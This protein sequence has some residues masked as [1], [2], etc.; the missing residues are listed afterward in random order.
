MFS[1]IALRNSLFILF[2]VLAHAGITYGQTTSFTYQGRLTD[3]GSAATATFDMQFKLFDGGGNQVGSTITNS[4]VTVTDGVFTVLLNFGATAFSGA[5][6]FLEIGIRPGGSPDAYTI[7]NPRQPVTSTPYAIRAANTSTADTATNATQL[8]GVNADQY[9]LTTDPRLAG[10]NNFIQNGNTQQAA[11]FN[12]SGNGNAAGILS[13]NVVNAATQY[14]LGATRFIS[15]PVFNTVVVGYSAGHSA[16]ASQDSTFVGYFAGS[17]STGQYNTFVGASTGRLNTTGE[18]NTFIGTYAGGSTKTGSYNSFVGY[19]TG[20]LNLS[21]SSNTFVGNGAGA[22]ANADGNS[23]FGKLAGHDTTTGFGNSFFGTQ[24][25]HDNKTASVNSFFGYL[26]GTNNTAIGNSFFGAYAGERN[27]TGQENSFF[28]TSAGRANLTA[29]GNAYFGDQSGLQST[30]ANNSFFGSG[31]GV[32][33]VAGFNNVFLGR[34]AGSINST[35]FNNTIIGTSA[36]VSAGGL[37][38]ATAIGS[39]ATVGTSNTI[40][41]GRDSGTD[42]VQI[43]G[44]LSVPK[45]G[46]IGVTS[47]CRNALNQLSTCS[48][49]LRYKKDI[50]PFTGGLALLNK[51]NPITFNWRTDNSPDLGFGAEEIAAIEPLLVVRDEKG[52]VEGV[53]YDRIT[54]VLVNAIK[55]QQQQINLQQ[56]QIEGLKKFICKR[57]RRARPCLSGSTQ[58]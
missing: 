27:T 11:N 9:V 29:T 55:E 16:S 5:D 35:G 45:L 15:T 56:Q 10:G 43:P 6:R 41:L 34:F 7:L 4:S 57:N 53:K 46:T 54:A 58:R 38:F 49:S 36:N 12:I 23:F 37:S 17:V 31:S 25:G 26:A 52:V 2:V 47:I 39:G 28:G 18:G 19:G 24:A 50:A 33:N 3:Q 48:S 44:L 1:H 51:L 32:N 14:N 40:V 22:F 30:G 8:G 20:L 13:G 21:G 42:L